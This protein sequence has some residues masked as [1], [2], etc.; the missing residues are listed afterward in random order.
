MA[1]TVRP[2]PHIDAWC[3]SVWKAVTPHSCQHRRSIPMQSTSSYGDCMLFAV[4]RSG[5]PLPLQLTHNGRVC[6]TVDDD[7]KRA[8]H[9][10]GTHSILGL[11]ATLLRLMH[12]SLLLLLPLS[13]ACSRGT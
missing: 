7:I 8:A 1:S 9:V 13:C 5:D 2:S 3:S 6:M 11:Y 10:Q 12:M 4:T